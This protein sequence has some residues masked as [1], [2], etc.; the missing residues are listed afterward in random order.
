MHI[1]KNFQ[2]SFLNVSYLDIQ[3]QKVTKMSKNS[4]TLEKKIA[5]TC[6]LQGTKNA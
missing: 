1:F 5:K 6:E 4:D 3:Y 2:Y